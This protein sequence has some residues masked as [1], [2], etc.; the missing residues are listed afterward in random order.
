MGEVAASQND[1]GAGLV[2]PSGASKALFKLA[3]FGSARGQP[4]GLKIDQDIS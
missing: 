2:R 1:I 4:L 3:F